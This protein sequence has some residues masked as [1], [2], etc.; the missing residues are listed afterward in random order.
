MATSKP[1]SGQPQ[2]NNGQHI[3][4]VDRPLGEVDL[5]DRSAVVNDTI[6]GV[7]TNTPFGHKGKTRKN[8]NHPFVIDRV[9]S[10]PSGWTIG[11]A[12]DQGDGIQ[13][14]ST[15]FGDDHENTKG[16]EFTFHKPL[17]PQHEDYNNLSS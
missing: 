5:Q 4:H 8:T 9:G 11:F 15:D 6:M 17:S 2:N 3:M 13:D 1:K 7:D 16:G 10:E 12:E 14:L